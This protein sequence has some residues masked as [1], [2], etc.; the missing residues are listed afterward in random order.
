MR[1]AET[2]VLKLKRPG[3]AKRRWLVETAE[4][5]RQGVELGL[6]CAL[7][8][9]TSSRGKI[10]N[11]VYASLRSLGLPADYA[12]M[13]VN[14]AVSLARSHF[15][16]RKAKRKAGKPVLRKNRG[17]GLGVHAYKVVGTALRVSTAVRGQYLWLPLSVPPHW[18]ARLQ[19]VH[20]DARLF[21]R[22]EDWFVMLPLKVPNT[23]TVRDGGREA[24]VIGVDLGIVR[25]AV[26]K[27]PDGVRIWN[28]KPVRHRRERFAALRR[29]YQRHR[30]TDR[31][32][33][34]RGRERRWM[35]DVNHK[36]SRGLVDLAARY[37]N[38][39]IALESLN[40]IRDRVRGSKRFNRM[41]ASW[42]FRQ[43]ADFIEYKAAKAGVRVVYVD[44]RRTSRT[45]PRC[46]HA[47][48]AN[49][50]A[51][52]RFRCVACGYQANADVVAAINIASV[53][54]G[55]LRQGPPGTARPHKGQAPSAAKGPDGVKAWELFGSHADS[56]LASPDEGTPGL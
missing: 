47:T 10:H 11:A 36:L 17:I 45:C 50:P 28:G 35:R 4:R 15:G 42:S 24:T 46:G 5:F 52:S 54:A 43:L 21:K 39:V 26:A 12:R 34:M 27:T 7:S 20:G 13:A 48:R 37:P 19:Y 53:A 23:P 9:K 32:R 51:Q 16:T 25:L 29:R 1:R 55:L 8:A 56:N 3:A 40:G 41:M 44:P 38:P 6:D 31:V 30:R 14:Q 49:R 2:V 18:R 33:A 22:G